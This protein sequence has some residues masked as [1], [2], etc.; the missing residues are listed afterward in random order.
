MLNNVESFG[1]EQF[2]TKGSLRWPLSWV[3]VSAS[4]HHLFDLASLSYGNYVHRHLLQLDVCVTGP[5]QGADYF[6]HFSAL[7]AAR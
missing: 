4:I 5:G 2:E 6:A 7:V 3:L 1:R